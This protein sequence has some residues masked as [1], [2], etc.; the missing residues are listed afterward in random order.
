MPCTRFHHSHEERGGN[1]NLHPA[2]YS[3][4]EP[5]SLLHIEMTNICYQWRVP[6][7]IHR[8]SGLKNSPL[9]YCI[10]IIGRFFK[11]KWI[12]IRRGSVRP[13]GPIWNMKMY[14]F[15]WV[16]SFSSSGGFF[17]FSGSA[18]PH[19]PARTPSLYIGIARLLA[20]LLHIRFRLLLRRQWDLGMGKRL[21]LELLCREACSSG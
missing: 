17:T 5:A 20:E 8:P 11:S 13:L 10:F 21:G 7:S 9:K 16:S 18:R 19:I 3:S 4:H 1:K 15:C 14:F 2:L 6:K 12:F